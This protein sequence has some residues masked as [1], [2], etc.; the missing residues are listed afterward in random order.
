MELT[1]MPSRE[2]FAPGWKNLQA[3]GVEKEV[4]KEKWLSSGL[5]FC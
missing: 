3:T 2:G 5:L 1:G 4:L